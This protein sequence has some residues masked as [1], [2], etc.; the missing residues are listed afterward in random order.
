[1]VCDAGASGVTLECR[2]VTFERGGILPVFLGHTVGG[3]PGDSVPGSVL[4][5]ER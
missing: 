3:Q 2:D 4:V 5:F 1:M